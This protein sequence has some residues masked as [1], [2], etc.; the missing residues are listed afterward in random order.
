MDSL[1]TKLLGPAITNLG[2]LDFPTRY[3]SLEL[4]RLIMPPGG[5]FPLAQVNL[6][7]GAV[8]CS[9]K[10]S[11]IV[12]YAQEAVGTATMAAI[13]D[14]AMAY[15]RKDVGGRAVAASPQYKDS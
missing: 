11:L 7:V 15:L 12:R 5:A 3:G 2:R 6:V 13:K 14:Q 9:G 1:D 8:T 4:V 10:L